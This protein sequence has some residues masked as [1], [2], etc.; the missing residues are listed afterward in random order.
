MEYARSD[1][2]PGADSAANGNHGDMACFEAT[3]Q[4]MP[5]I[6]DGLDS[7]VRMCEALLLLDCIDGDGVVVV[8]AERG[9]VGVVRGALSP[10]P[11][12]HCRLCRGSGRC[13]G[14]GRAEGRSGRKT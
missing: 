2:K 9:R 3:M 11:D 6:V 5:A 13:G 1:D 14:G 7:R 4:A 8:L 10:V 12:G